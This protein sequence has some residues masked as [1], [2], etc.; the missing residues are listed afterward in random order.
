MSDFYIYFAQAGVDGPV[1]I[2]RATDLRSRLFQLQ[3]ASP[4][5]ILLLA[6][7]RGPAQW[8]A[9]FQKTCEPEH[10]RGEWFRFGDR[11]KS[12][13]WVVH[14]LWVRMG[15]PSRCLWSSDESD[16]WNCKN[17]A[18]DETLKRLHVDLWSESVA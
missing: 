15:R 5:E 7:I 17:T 13:V 16:Y 11:T 14:Q 8:E 3:T 6:A 10:L 2:G 18:R 9:R 4:Y 1:K 12:L